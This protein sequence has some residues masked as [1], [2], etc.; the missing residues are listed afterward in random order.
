MRTITAIGHGPGGLGGVWR[1]MAWMP[2]IEVVRA[3][4]TALAAEDPVRVVTTL[5]AGFPLMVAAAALLARDEGAPVTLEAVLAHP[6]PEDDRE[7]RA[8]FSWARRA[9]ARADAA[10]VLF[11]REPRNPL[12]TRAATEEVGR[13]LLAQADLVLACWNGRRGNRT[14]AALHRVR[15]LEV[16][17]LYPEI[18]RALRVP[19]RELAGA[20]GV[21]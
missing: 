11:P 19:V 2:A 15:G 14:W 16:E 13:A 9:L 17:N 3:R 10:K 20:E 5:E 4:L 18:A 6:L 12:E 21:G 8:V 1:P 7:P